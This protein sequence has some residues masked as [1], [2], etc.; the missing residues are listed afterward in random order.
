VAYS[1]LE[2]VSP[3][4]GVE[5]NRKST[6]LL[7][8]NEGTM[9]GAPLFLERLANGLAK[10]TKFHVVVFFSSGGPIASRMQTDGV[11]TYISVKRPSSRWKLIS[12]FHR[13]VHYLKFIKTL[14]LVRPNVV[15]SNTIVNCGE[16]VLSR[17]FGFP[18]VLHMHE[19]MN[20]ASKLRNKLLVHG[21]SRA[22]GQPGTVFRHPD[23][24]LRRGV[25]AVAGAGAGG[26]DSGDGQADRG[27]R[28]GRRETAGEGFPRAGGRAAREDGRE[29][30][31]CADAEDP[32]H[33]GHGRAGDRKRNRFRPQP[34]GWGRGSHAAGGVHRQTGCRTA[35][36][37]E[38][39]AGTVV[40]QRPELQVGRARC[41]GR[42]QQPLAGG[43]ELVRRRVGAVEAGARVIQIGGAAGGPAAGHRGVR[44]GGE[45]FGQ[46]VSPAAAC[47]ERIRGRDIQQITGRA[48]DGV[49]VGGEA[50]VADARDGRERRGR[51]GGRHRQGG[52]C[53]AAVGVGAREVEGIRGIFISYRSTSTLSLTLT[54]RGKV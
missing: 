20:F 13:V 19:G 42:A 33:A 53:R 51:Q 38:G 29:D 7:I 30:P 45:I 9:T 46:H 34:G 28:R 47:G 21:A 4:K 3:L 10:S 18:T 40:A 37:N 49:P 14:W 2:I 31:R 25:S 15:Y 52:R 24:A 22:A 50:V 11:E 54:V 8:S 41:E 16:T 1:E 17:V 44:Q 12:L 32:V 6:V 23:R 35:G 27:G 39:T 26:A 36:R 48:G 43:L 5:K